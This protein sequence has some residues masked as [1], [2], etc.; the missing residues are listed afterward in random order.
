MF[1]STI[2]GKTLR[3]LRNIPYQ[4]KRRYKYLVFRRHAEFGE[5]LDL[6]AGSNCSAE[7]PGTITIGDHC[8]IYG[9]LQTQG[10]GEIRIG[11]H[12]CIYLDTVIGSVESIRIGDCVIIS[13]HVHI[14]DNN[15]H[16]TDPQVRRQMCMAGF[17]G[18]DWKWTRSQSAPIV[19]EDNVWIGE[20]AAVMK[21]VTIGE[22]AV[23]ASHA[24]VTKDVPPYTIVAGNPAKV[25]KEIDN[26]T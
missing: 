2:I 14:Y 15:N 3:S 13:N 1:L 6:C 21:G 10:N 8:R 20:Y 16:P 9:R 17:D 24:V 7:Q 19:I 23:V 12:C 18:E 4:V 26:G 11:N 5:N 22:G 25:V